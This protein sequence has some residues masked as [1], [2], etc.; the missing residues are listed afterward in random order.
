MMLSL[1]NIIK[2][3]NVGWEEIEIL[4]G[5]SLAIEEGEFV[6]IMGPSGSGKSTLM[7]II[8]LLDTPT[9]G[10]YIL[11]NTPL[12]NISGDQQ[13]RFRGEKIWFIFQWYNLIARMSALDQVMLPLSYQW[14]S[15]PER[16][17]R[18]IDALTRVWLEAK[19]NSKP[20]ELSGWQQQRV[21]IA[22]AIVANPAILLADEPTGALDSRTGAEVMNILQWLHKEWKTI[23]LI[24]HD[25]AIAAFA[26][27]IVRIKDGVLE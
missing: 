7:N 8:W 25:S 26:Q 19:I 24:T 15:I 16:R 27:K 5:I 1:D 13:S 12:E 2:S 23:V 17:K 6:A 22:R 4:K 9:S 14:I 3:Y 20:N 11:D 10:S 18:W 21:A